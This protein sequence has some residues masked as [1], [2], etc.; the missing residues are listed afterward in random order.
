MT[1]QASEIW[2]FQFSKKPKLLIIEDVYEFIFQ[3]S[4][5]IKLVS[6]SSFRLWFKYKG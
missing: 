3:A 5:T 6:N 2:S 1:N 4:S